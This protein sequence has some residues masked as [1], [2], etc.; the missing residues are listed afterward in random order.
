MDVVGVKN[1]KMRKVGKVRLSNSGK[2][3]LSYN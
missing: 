3:I 2:V 1:R